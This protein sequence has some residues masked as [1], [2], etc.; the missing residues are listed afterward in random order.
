MHYCILAFSVG[1][2]NFDTIFI[3]NLLYAAYFGG[4]VNKHGGE[5]LDSLRGFSGHLGHLGVGH[6]ISSNQGQV[7]MCGS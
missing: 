3:I 1:T 7:G 4:E 6:L 2:E 5:L